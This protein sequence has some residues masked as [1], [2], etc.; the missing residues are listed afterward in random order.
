MKNTKDTQEDSKT[1]TDANVPESSTPASG[2]LNQK[3]SDKLPKTQAEFEAALRAAKL[4][5]AKETATQAAKQIQ[6]LEEKVATKVGVNGFPKIVVEGKTHEL[7]F[8]SRMV[9]KNDDGDTQSISYESMINDGVAKQELNMTA[10]EV[11]QL[12]YS[13]HPKAFTEVK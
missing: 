7:Q 11:V 9:I 6:K 5:G 2:Q 4:E 3:D 13:K 10:K 1:Q 8:C 12:L